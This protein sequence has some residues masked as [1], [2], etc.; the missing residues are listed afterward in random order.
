M[1][2]VVVS[3]ETC[4]VL[5]QDIGNRLFP[6]GDNVEPEQKVYMVWNSFKTFLYD[7]ECELFSPK[8]Y[9]CRPYHWVTDDVACINI[10]SMVYGEPQSG[11]IFISETRDVEGE[12]N[13]TLL[14]TVPIFPFYIYSIE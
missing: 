7:D 1:P 6:D 4:P 8:N 3:A 10:Q 14:H 9:I 13:L 12:L 11:S 5:I 2:A